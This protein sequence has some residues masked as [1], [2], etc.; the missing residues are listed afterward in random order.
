MQ[1][2]SCLSWFPKVPQRC[3]EESQCLFKKTSITTTYCEMDKEKLRSS[4]AAMWPTKR[5][6]LYYQRT[7]Q[8]E[9]RLAYVA[10]CR[11]LILTQ[12]PKPPHLSLSKARRATTTDR[13][14]L[15]PQ[16]TREQTH[17]M[18]A[19]TNTHYSESPTVFRHS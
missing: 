8:F 1:L 18:F 9:V 5:K 10:F 12:I 14:F 11:H 7:R 19:L 17:V 15:R 4:R 2:C 6:T 13:V 3:L 16:E